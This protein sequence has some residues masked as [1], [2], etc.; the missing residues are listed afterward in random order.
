MIAA[1]LT[2]ALTRNPLKGLAVLLAANPRPATI[3]GEYAWNHAELMANEKNYTVPNN[4]SLAQLARTK[5][6]LIEDNSLL[7]T[8]VI[9][10]VQWQS[11]INE[12]DSDK[13]I[14]LAAALM[15]KS[16]HPWKT[17]VCKQAETTCHTIRTAY[18]IEEGT[19]GLKGKINNAI[20]LIGSLSYLDENGI[21]CEPYLLDEKRLRRKGFDVLFVAKKGIKSNHCIGLLISRQQYNSEYSE[22]IKHLSMDGWSIGFMQES[23]DMRSTSFPFNFD[24]SWI[25]L[26]EREWMD[27]IMDLK[28]SGEDVLYVA[29]SDSPLEFE[30]QTTEVPYMTMQQLK[31][32]GET[33]QYARKIDNSVKQQTYLTQGWNVIGSVLAAIGVISAP[34][35]NLAADVLSLTFLSRSK[36]ISE[37]PLLSQVD[38]RDTN[39]LY[40]L[41]V[42]AA[43]EA[44]LSSD[45]IS[46]HTSPL[47]FALAHFR[48]NEQQ[49][50]TSD[51]VVNSRQKYGMNQLEGKKPIS[52]LVSYLMQFKE[53]TTLILLGTSLLALFSGDIFDGIAMGSILLANSAIG[54]IQERRAEKVVD[55]LNEFQP[56]ICKAIRNGQHVELPAAELV[57]G[58]LVSLEAGDRIPADLRLIRSWSLQ[59]NEAALTGESV[60]I[61][62]NER[63]LIRGLS[64]SRT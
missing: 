39:D 49:G 52:F 29:A 58:D 35:V 10:D 63:Q 48:V 19:T 50:L 9:Q 30:N 57:P 15:K 4:G 47:E 23:L 33:L 59:I 13:V 61:E 16:S 8:K 64:H 21:D 18:Q 20:F 14:C 56:P 5:T 27:R 31:S 43:S 54:T 40:H 28:K 55:T 51:Q 24:R 17:E 6:L 12:E 7:F 2:W 44:N 41:E 25:G 42:A 38:L 45:A 46:W 34:L 36:K 37:E 3:P 26:Q 62:K 22:V 53:F 1:G 32:I 60:P 11:L